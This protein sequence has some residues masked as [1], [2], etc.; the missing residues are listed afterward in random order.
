MKKISF[1]LVLI[2]SIQGCGFTP[3]YVSNNNNI[4]FKIENIT[5]E[6]DQELNN[7]ININLKKYISKD[8]N[9]T[10]FKIS[11]TSSYSKLAQS[12]DAKGNIQSFKVESFITFKVSGDNQT[13]DLIYSEQS[14]L[15][16]SDDTFE[17]KS[18]ES[19]IKQNFA[20][21]VVEK[22]LLDLSNRQ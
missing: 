17:L 16:N 12:K 11:T 22:L 4:N 19:S 15:N 3:V 9:S 1:L 20:S 21:S 13:F 14:D 8:S 5:F 7:Y 6:G 2:I 18:Y 10:N